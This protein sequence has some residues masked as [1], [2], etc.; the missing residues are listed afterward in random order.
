MEEDTGK[1]WDR[2]INA[3]RRL[4]IVMDDQRTCVTKMHK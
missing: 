1:E 4:I 2:I 3:Y